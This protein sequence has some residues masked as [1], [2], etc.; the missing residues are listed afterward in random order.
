ML[1]TSAAP[2]CPSCADC[3]RF[4]RDIF[5]SALPRPIDIDRPCYA[6]PPALRM[7]ERR[8]SWKSRILGAQAVG[9]KGIDKRIDVRGTVHDLAEVELSATR[10]SSA[11]PRIPS[12]SPACW[13]PMRSGA[14]FSR[15]TP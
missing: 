8:R 13:R 5:R 12:T 3:A 7:A 11:R 4:V 9:Q 2:G 15:P 14:T 6:A 10:R 1:H